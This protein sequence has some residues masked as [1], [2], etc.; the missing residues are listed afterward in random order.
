MSRPKKPTIEDKLQ[1]RMTSSLRN[2]KRGECEP[3]KTGDMTAS[4]NL[5]IESVVKY[6]G[7]QCKYPPTSKGLDDFVQKSI[8][9][10]DYCNEVNADPE[11]EKKLIP[12]VESWA[13]YL[14]TT[15]TTIFEYEKRGGEWS[16]AIAFFKNAIGSAKKQMAL[17]GKIPPVLY[18]FD[19]TNNHG[20]VN[21][22]EFKMEAKTTVQTSEQTQ[23]ERELV[24]N[25]LAWNEET[26]SFEPITGEIID[27]D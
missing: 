19:S 3:I 5:I 10:F 24:D 4:L 11:L 7:R 9:F 20:Y 2:K 21:A 16:E 1:A 25:N 6:H 18:I 22:A 14:G 8:D 17:N 27:V 13:L 26:H 23:L 12:D 15:R